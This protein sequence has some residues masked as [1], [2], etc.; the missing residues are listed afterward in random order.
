MRKT[1]AAKKSS[2]PSAHLSGK[3]LIR[4]LS[5]RSTSGE[6]GRRLKL[7]LPPGIQFIIILGHKDILNDFKLDLEPKLKTRGK[8]HKRKMKHT[9]SKSHSRFTLANTIQ[10]RPTS[11]DTNREL[12]FR[13][14]ERLS[15]K[16]IILITVASLDINNKIKY[17]GW[18]KDSELFAAEKCDAYSPDECDK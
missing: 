10:K 6:R 12:Q 1:E 4:K 11:K 17:S 9:K 3:S 2:K 16:V 5:P 14:S 13:L 8:S 7:S 15:Q 18:L